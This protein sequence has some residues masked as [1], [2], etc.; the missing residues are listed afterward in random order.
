M[1]AASADWR[2]RALTVAAS[3]S[4]GASG[5]QSDLR[6]FAA[7]GVYGVSAAALVAA[8]DTLAVRRVF[9]LAPSIVAA[10]IDTV[11][12]DI[13]ADACKIGWYRS[14]EL[15]AIIAGRV[16]RRSIPQVVLDPCLWSDAGALLTPPRT[17][18]RLVREL[19]P[20]TTVLCAT[21]RELS[22][23]AGTPVQTSADLPAAV[24]QILA[25]GT[26]SV[27][28]EDP[29]G[30]GA[31]WVG[32]SAGVR[33]VAPWA[34]SPHPLANEGGLFSA[35]LTAALATGAH[36]AEA[37]CQAVAFVESVRPQAQPLGRGLPLWAPGAIGGQP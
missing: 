7:C 20:C 35:A 10:Q 34:N 33:P 11:L 27:V 28:I 13:G 31:A 24:R 16:R 22:V 15:T 14:P 4:S 8:Q 19:L 21:P 37:V 18:K 12:R 9:K 26:Q 3:D 1:P 29:Q 30:E 32:D 25:L 2:A 36:L 17:V 6:V 23:L 5:I